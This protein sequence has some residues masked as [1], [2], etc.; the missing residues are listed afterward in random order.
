MRLISLFSS[1]IAH[2]FYNISSIWSDVVYVAF[3]I[4]K[5]RCKTFCLTLSWRRPILYRNQSIDLRSKLMYWFLYDICLRHERVKMFW[6]GCLKAFK[7]GSRQ[8][9]RYSATFSFIF[10]KLNWWLIINNPNVYIRWWTSKLLCQ[11]YHPFY[12]SI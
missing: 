10:T 2:S 4:K 6:P 12:V 7:L 9:P 5:I 1:E 11:F 8:H 3:T